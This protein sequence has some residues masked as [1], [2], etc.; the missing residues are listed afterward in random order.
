MKTLSDLF[1]M[2]ICEMLLELTMNIIPEKSNHPEVKKDSLLMA[3]CI[4]TYF[5]S[6]T[7][8]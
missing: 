7:K 5:L 1:R 2:M 8:K 4:F 3:R 6:Q